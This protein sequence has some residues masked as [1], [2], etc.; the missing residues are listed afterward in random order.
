VT[1]NLAGHTITGMKLGTSTGIE[2][3]ASAVHA[4]IGT[5]KPGAA[6]VAFHAGIQDYANNAVIEGPGLLL[7]DN[8]GA[9]VFLFKV[10][11]S[12]VRGANLSG[13]GYFG[14][15]VQLSQGVVL[16]G[17]NIDMNTTYGIWVQSTVASRFVDNVV[18][19]SGVAGIYLGCSD[20]ANLQEVGCQP[21]DGS[22]VKGNILHN[23]GPYGIAI[24]DVSLDNRIDMNTALGA[25]QAGL[26]DENAGCSG[27]TAPPN[28]WQ[29]N[30]GSRNQTVSATCIG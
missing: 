5:S 17:N 22:L 14:A 8:V 26:W 28:V 7:T 27:P 11:A 10:I 18:D 4:T 3:L 2:L 12:V 19:N 25:V 23:N 29:Q 15:N 24:A 20:T 21:S 30:V 16:R 1:L 9:G 13:N 6:V